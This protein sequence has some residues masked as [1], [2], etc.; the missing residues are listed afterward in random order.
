M[1]SK[2]FGKNFNTTLQKVDD[3]YNWIN[4]MIKA[5]KELVIQY[6]K[7]L[8][9]SVSR[10]SNKNEV[11]YPS[12]E[13]VT[14]FCDQLVDYMSHGHFDLFCRWLVIRRARVV[15]RTWGVIV[16]HDLHLMTVSMILT[17]FVALKVRKPGASRS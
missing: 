12:Y 7:I 16:H 13:D 3:K 4:D 8:N 9:V 1:S 14:K 15:R 17:S 5:R 11:C 2:Q 10:S 6:M